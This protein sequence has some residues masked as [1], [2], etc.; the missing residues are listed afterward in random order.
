MKHTTRG[1]KSQMANTATFKGTGNSPLLEWVFER[2]WSDRP[3]LIT[4]RIEEIRSV[5]I[6]VSD[7]PQELLESFGYLKTL[8]RG[9]SIAPIEKR[10]E[11]AFRHIILEDNLV[12]LEYVLRRGND[13]KD[14][15]QED[16]F[17]RNKCYLEWVEWHFSFLGIWDNPLLMSKVIWQDKEVK[18]HWL[19]K[20][21]KVPKSEWVARSEEEWH[22]HNL[23]GMY[24][25]NTTHRERVWLDN[26]KGHQC[27]LGGCQELR[28]KGL[29]PLDGHSNEEIRNDIPTAN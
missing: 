27:L 5:L 19:T 22:R 28:E 16:Y 20:W 6:V 1:G 3:N 26:H 14:K 7:N 8:N 29:L 18:P 2:S 9:A 21:C 23:E 10:V 24:P 25:T 12:H 17:T 11:K 4:S 13:K 15:K